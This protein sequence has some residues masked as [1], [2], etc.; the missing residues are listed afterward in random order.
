MSQDNGC[1]ATDSVRITQ[2]VE[3]PVVGIVPPAILNCAVTSVELDGA[4]SSQG[5]EFNYRWS[6]TDGTITGTTTAPATATNAPGSYQLRVTDGG[7]F[8][9]DSLTVTVTQDTV[10]PVALIQPAAELNCGVTSLEL[11]GSSSSSGSRYA[12]SWTGP[13][14][15]SGPTLPVSSPGSYGLLVTDNVNFCRSEAGITVTQD[16]MT[17][18]FSLAP[19]E[20]LDCGRT[21]TDLVA[22]TGPG[23]FRTEQWTFLGS[24]TDLAGGATATTNRPGTYRFLLV[25]ADNQCRDSATV[26]VIQDLAVP[27]VTVA[28][29]FDLACTQGSVNL[30][31]SAGGTGD[32]RFAWSSPD[33]TIVSGQDSNQP[34]ILGAGAYTVRVTNARNNCSAEETVTVA[35]T[36]LTGFG[37][38]ERLPDCRRPEGVIVFDSVAGGTPPFLYSVDGGE[39]FQPTTLFSDLD[40]GN[41]A[42]VVQDANGCEERSSTTLPERPDLELFLRADAEISFGDSIR[43]NLRA[44]F[45]EAEIDTIIWTPA[46]GL[47][48]TDC[49]TPFARPTQTGR[50]AVRVESIDGCVAEAGISIIVDRTRPVYFPTAFSPNG[51]GV[52]DLWYPFASSKV[53]SRIN[54]MELFDRWGERMYVAEDFAP[55]DPA[56]GWNG[57]MKDK[58]MNPAVFVFYAEVTFTDGSVEV[59]EG[60]F[61]LMR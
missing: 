50:Y 41:Y 48:C 3:Q 9:A 28:D 18:V 27:T 14:T 17:P 38:S 51:D 58:P 36:L 34:A 24:D 35:Q 57:M 10:S 56:A 37:F 16:T 49:L 55:S 2:D 40:P 23:N 30:T 44:S 6:T 5:P 4:A 20:Q 53:V 43:L 39:R 47:S 52:N 8:C 13:A 32:F 29:D 22:T 7:N 33:G 60:D 25:D 61:T 19:P 45:P 26:E 1:R 31:A 15:G 12:Y 46:A 59:F 42:L 21:T 54:R 11:D